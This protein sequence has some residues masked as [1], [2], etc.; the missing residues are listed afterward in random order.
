MLQEGAVELVEQ[1]GPGFYRQLFLVEKVTGLEARHRPLIAEQLRHHHKVQD[2][3]R[4]FSPGISPTGGLDVLCRS[5]G[6]RFPDP[7]P[8]GVSPMSTPLPRG[9]C[10]PVQGVLW[11]VQGSAG[12]RSGF[13]VD[14][15]EGL[16]PSP[17]SGR[18]AGGCGVAG[19]TSSPSG[20]S[21]PAVHRSWNCGQLEVGHC[22]QYLGMVL[23]MFLEWVFPS[24]DRLSHF[25]E[26]AT[27]FFL[28]PSPPA[29]M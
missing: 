17:L 4:R 24:Q 8:S 7:S 5:P 15:S 6:H 9:S 2:G 28:L 11:P 10:L 12:L 26:V 21:S 22:L 27:S 3:D 20:P 18:L 1:P 25:R 19:H 14:A 13:R 23:D 16:A 29:H